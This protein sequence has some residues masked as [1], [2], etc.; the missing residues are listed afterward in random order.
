MRAAVLILL[1]NVKVARPRRAQ[2]PVRV[3]AE[4]AAVGLEVTDACLACAGIGEP[5]TFGSVKHA[6]TVL[7]CTG[8]DAHTPC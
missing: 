8:R 4:V 1:N 7:T 6:G 3:L 5:L 2:V